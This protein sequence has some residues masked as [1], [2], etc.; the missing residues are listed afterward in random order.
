MSEIIKMNVETIKKELDVGI[1]MM[2]WAEEEL[3]EEAYGERSERSN[4]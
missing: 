4:K 3:I 1:V 2:S